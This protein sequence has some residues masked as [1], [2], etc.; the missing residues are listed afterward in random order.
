M[1]L[2]LCECEMGVVTL[3]NEVKL[4]NLRGVNL[5][6]SGNLNITAAGNVSIAAPRITIYGED[7]VEAY[8]GPAIEIDE[9]VFDVDVRAKVVLSSGG[10]GVGDVDY[11][12]AEKTYFLAWDS[13]N[14][15]ADSFRYRDI[16]EDG[17][18]NWGGLV[19]NVTGGIMV[20]I[21]AGVCVYTGV[22]AVASN[23]VKVAAAMTKAG[24]TAGSVG[25]TTAAVATGYTVSLAIS[26]VMSGRVSSRQDYVKKALAGSVVG[27][28]AGASALA[29]AGMGAGGNMAVG[30]LEGAAGSA[31]SQGII[32]GEIQLDQVIMDGTFSGVVELGMWG[33]RSAV[34]GTGNSSI[35]KPGDPDFIGPLSEIEAAKTSNWTKPDGSTWWPPNDGGVPGTEVSVTLKKGTEVGRIGGEGGSYVAHPNTSPEKL[36]L[37]PGTDTS[38]YHEYIVIKDI[39]DVQQAEIAGWFGMPGGGTQYKLPLSIKDLMD[40]GYI[41]LLN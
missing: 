5:S 14:L 29:R 31:A 15:S 6:A 10:S 33:W 22:G 8:E 26:D 27:F 4:D 39:T 21:L 30:A 7:G 28:L 38:N 23:S 37:K 18:Y 34:K 36:A 3:S 20:G 32:D 17:Y 25:A 35:P 12:G 9:G 40:A 41:E 19:R 24:V 2:R 1:Q 11:R 16:P 13:E